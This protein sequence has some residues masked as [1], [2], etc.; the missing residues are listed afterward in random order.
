MTFPAASS[1]FLPREVAAEEARPPSTTPRRV[2]RITACWWS[3][4]EVRAAVVRKMS[5]D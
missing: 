4:A 2:L 3:Q 1:L 5:W